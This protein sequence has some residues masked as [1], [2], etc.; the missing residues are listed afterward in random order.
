MCLCHRTRRW[1]SKT[2]GCLD[3]AVVFCMAHFSLCEGAVPNFFVLVILLLTDSNSTNPEVLSAIHARL[4][5]S[6][7]CPGM[8]LAVNACCQW[9][10]TLTHRI[11][12]LFPWPGGIQKHWR[13]SP[14]PISLFDAE[15]RKPIK[16]AYT[17]EHIC[18]VVPI[19]YLKQ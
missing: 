4:I 6:Q 15:F 7:D 14:L 11:T 3:S 12:L 9:A 18:L 13:C 5:F 17:T 16:P 2:E 8:K 19:C 1:I 10:G